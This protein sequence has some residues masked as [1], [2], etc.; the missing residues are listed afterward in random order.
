MKHM[1]KH[2]WNEKEKEHVKN[3]INKYR[4]ILIN[5]LSLNIFPIANVLYKD[6]I[7]I[8]G[9]CR[10]LKDNTAVIT[11][12]YKTYAGGDICL[13][14]TI[15]H[16][17]LHAMNDT[18]GHDSIFHQRSNIVNRYLG[19]RI[20]TYASKEEQELTKQ[21]MLSKYKYKLVCNKCGKE[22]FY[23]RKTSDIKKAINNNN[24]HISNLIHRTCGN[25]DDGFTLVIL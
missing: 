18:K 24:M 2:V 5:E 23:S 8:F 6:S 11:I 13:R 9:S 12:H 7:N 22:F 21:Y 3:L 16:E 25:T 4:D 15:C 19:T 1:M 10:R 20:G 17:L 14:D